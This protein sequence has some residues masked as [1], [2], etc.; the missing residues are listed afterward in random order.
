MADREMGDDFPEQDFELD[1]EGVSADDLSGKGEAVEKE[2]WYHFEV[3][4]VKPELGTVNDKGKEQTPSINFHLM[5]L[6]S[7]KDQSPAGSRAYHR[8]YLASSGG[9]PIKDGSRNSALRFG[10]GLG[11]LA[12]IPSDKE[13][14]QEKIVDKA[15]GSTRIPSSVWL[16]AKGMQFI[17]KIK[18]NPPEEG[19]KYTKGKYEIP[20][21]RCYQVDDPQ[22]ADI[23]KNAE[24]LAI[25]GKGGSNG[26]APTK[27]TSKPTAAAS[28]PK[29]A[30]P[31]TVSPD[32]DLSDL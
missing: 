17:A 31:A 2:G 8:I 6:E 12:A 19:S 21:G 9:H 4:D 24:A 3:A 1:T 16:R 28:A 26:P 32:D 13:E 29:A 30:A 23:P 22:V 27:A 5:V 15:T 18:Y 10:L 7:V 20:F 25:L 14:G 11:L